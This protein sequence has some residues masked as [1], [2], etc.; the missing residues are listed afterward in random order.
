MG[1]SM[2][3]AQLHYELHLTCVTELH[4]KVAKPRPKHP[5]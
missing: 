2:Q 4:Q 3:G 5:T 1:D